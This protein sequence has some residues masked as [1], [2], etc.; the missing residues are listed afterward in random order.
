MDAQLFFVVGE[1]ECSV[2]VDVPEESKIIK[3]ISSGQRSFSS[4][5]FVL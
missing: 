1:G 3:V 5:D 2:L 4:T